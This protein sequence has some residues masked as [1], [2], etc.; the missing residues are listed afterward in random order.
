MRLQSLRHHVPLTFL[1]S[2]LS[3]L[4]FLTAPAAQ[5]APFA[6][7]SNYGTNG[8][9]NTVSVIDTATNTVTATVTVGHGPY[10]VGV[11]PD[12]ARV[13]V[14][15]QF[16]DTISVISTAT[17]TV[18]ATLAVGSRPFGVAVTPDG[19]RVYIPNFFSAN[20]SVVSTATNTVIATVALAGGSTPSGVAIT[21]DGARVYVVSGNMNVVNGNTLNAVSVISTATNAVIAT[22][23]V[24]S[25]SDPIGMAITPDGAR[26]YVANVSSSVGTVSVI[27]T[28]TNTVI[29]TVVVGVTPFGVA[30]TPDGTRV[31]V[32]DFNNASVSVISTATNIV[33]A[34]IGVGAL[35]AGVAITPDGARVYVTNSGNAD[36]SVISTA[37]NTVTAT[38]PVGIGPRGLGLF[39]IPPACVWAPAGMVAWWSLDEK[40]GTT[41]AD[42]VG[43]FDG[44]AQPGNIGGPGPATSASGPPTFPF[45][46][47]KVGTS[48]SFTGTQRVEVLTNPALE[49]GVGDFTIDAWVIYAAAG[50][51][52][53]LTI[54]AKGS[55]SAPGYLLNIQDVS[56][57]Q[58]L[59]K[60]FVFGPS[61]APILTA[62]MAPQTWHHVAATLQRGTAQNMALYI[63]GALVGSGPVGSGGSVSNT[64]PLFIGGDVAS[65][66]EIAVD[67]VE[68]FNRAL[69]QPEIQGIFDAGPAGK[70]KCVSPPSGMVSWWPLDETGGT[71]V[72]DIVGSNN[73]TP[74]AGPV[75]SGGPT[76]AS[77][78]V[79]GALSF[80]G[81]SDFV[82]VP[83]A[84]NLNFGTGALSIDAWI[85]IPPRHGTNVMPIVEKEVI[86]FPNSSPYGY[87]FYVRNGHLGFSIS[88]DFNITP[89][90]SIHA[91]ET[92]IDLADDLWHH[93]AVTV[94]LNPALGTLFIDGAP[95]PT[96]FST[97]AFA[98]FTADNL[99]NLFI[100]S[101]NALIRISSNAYFEG[102]IDEIEIFRRPL[103]PTEIHDIYRAGS[104]GKCK[105]ACVSPPSG[106]VAWWTLDETPGSTVIHDIWPNH[107]NGTPVPS[108]VGPP[109]SGP[110]SLAGQYVNDSLYLG[111]S[112]VDVPDSPHLNFF[113]PGGTGEF[114][115]DAWINTFR[116]TNGVG[117]TLPVVDKTVVVGSKVTGYALYLYPPA[118]GGPS[119]LA[120]TLGDGT[121]ALTGPPSLLSPYPPDGAWHHVTVTVARPSLAS[122]AVTLYVDGVPSSATISVANTNN[123]ADL[124]IGKGRLGSLLGMGNGSEF[125]I[126]EVEIFNGVLTPQDVLEVY[127]AHSVGKCRQRGYGR[128]EPAP[129]PGISPKKIRP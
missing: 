122:A 56:T 113:P 6:Y 28:A 24:G 96:P 64:L 65:K 105:L 59:L 33:T 62:N 79:A 42:R 108:P 107:L 121:V 35:P 2:L 17:N 18:I 30:V 117:I 36:V 14:A 93:V 61:S 109:G 48:L 84:P 97:T 29:A 81:T 25:G 92:T 99:G 26:V 47:G 52:N 49:P 77:G 68:L 3:G 57:T 125:A 101:A 74:K 90:G 85:K 10:G 112:Y 53:V 72:N 55:T 91:E 69:S 22:V 7:I 100:G 110:N 1:T 23:A 83:N 98:G 40:S 106:M 71:I 54:V 43:G 118:T 70:C 38:V 41:V 60:F 128:V 51:G 8:T 13:Y 44:T 104:A 46:A 50:T 16:S 11:T 129:G 78:M 123:S 34:T 87:N 67:E 114:S 31:Y 9:G 89:H 86:G 21:P 102:S 120:F 45:P 111:F 126:D 94:L 88:S 20:V 80:N 63:D 27:S 76:P 73:G 103:A 4:V 5:A 15:N 12:G 19:A 32:S 115:I 66:G 75:G 127:N 119:Q 124:W 37:T 39:I 116:F 95:L 82:Q 58:G